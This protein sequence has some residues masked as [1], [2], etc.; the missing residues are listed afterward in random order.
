MLVGTR[1]VGALF[2]QLWWSRW[3][4][5]NVPIQPKFDFLSI[6]HSVVWYLMDSLQ[7]PFS[8]QE[9]SSKTKSVSWNAAKG[10]S[11]RTAPPSS[12]SSCWPSATSLSRE[13]PLLVLGPI[14]D[15]NRSYWHSNHY[16]KSLSQNLHL[17][18]I[19]NLLKDFNSFNWSRISKVIFDKAKI[20]RL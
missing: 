3:T 7:H 15:S 5:W 1:L 14:K 16:S 10:W 9:I 17:Q 19:T 8:V 20:F 13:T 4:P 2:H 18:R 6:C 11:A 12:P